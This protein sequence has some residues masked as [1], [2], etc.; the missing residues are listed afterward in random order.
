M[1]KKIILFTK[2]PYSIE[3]SELKIK[4]LISQ[5]IKLYLIHLLISL[6]IIVPVAY[7]KSIFEVYP[8]DTDLLIKNILLVNVFNYF[9][10]PFIE[11]LAFRL[12]L[13]YKKIHLSF[14]IS[15]LVLSFLLISLKSPNYL[16]LAIVFIVMT[17]LLYF[18]FSSN[19]KLDL[20]LSNSWE[21]NFRF[22]FYFFVIAFGFMHTF[23]YHLSCKV[24]FL[25]PL[26]VLP[27][28]ISGV[29]YSYAR[30]KFGFLSAIIQHI[31]YNL[32]MM[33]PIIFFS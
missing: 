19:S 1:I 5:N 11:E 30:I 7:L 16:A 23:N 10:L 24:L 20:L 31:V 25:A 8:R 12:S 33:L 32:T 14:S 15:S 27:Q 13:V 6:I 29:L 2:K 9:V 26:I 28:L 4:V 3:E 18:L 17:L 21:R 22:I